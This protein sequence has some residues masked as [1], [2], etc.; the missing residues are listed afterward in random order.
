MEIK[1]KITYQFIV[2]VAVILTISLTA[3]YVSFSELRKEE[4]YDRLSSKAKLAAQLLLEIDEI[5][6]EVLQK[7]E[8]NN[9]LSLPKEKIIIFDYRD[10]IIFSSDTTSDISISKSLINDTRLE[11]A[12][13]HH[14]GDYEIFGYFY[15]SQYDRVVIFTAATDIFGINKLER[16]RIVLIV[17]FIMG[18]VIVFIS[19]KLF[20]SRALSPISEIIKKVDQ[21]EATNLFQRLDEGN[22][23][24]EIAHLTKTFN[25]ML[26]RIETAF[27][28]QKNFIANASHELRTPLTIITGQIEVVLMKERHLEEYKATLTDVLQDIKNL[29][30]ISNRLLL[31]AQASSDFSEM[32][33]SIFRVDDAIWQAQQEVIRRNKNYTININFTN[34]IDSEDKLLIRGNELLIRTAVANLFDNGCKYSEDQS[35]DLLV[36]YNSDY[37]HLTF[38]DNG[39][40]IPQEDHGHIFQPFFRSKNT[41]NIKGHGIGL[42]LVEKIIT[43]HKGSIKV[44]SELDRGSVFYIIIPSHFK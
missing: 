31:L 39:Y 8:R 6:I 27:R 30:H 35:I 5:D 33:F 12:T 17:V 7:I 28:S 3:I 9:P 14:Q 1:K 13:Q 40:G 15:T 26:S 20:S 22:G 32:D 25:K 29:N 44:K 2:I 37:I 21:I 16:L 4:F 10:N 19:G 24:D 41:I 38:T 42:S 18:L 43:L 34:S 23:K 11:G 36:D